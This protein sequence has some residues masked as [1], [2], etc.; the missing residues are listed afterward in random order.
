MLAYKLGCCCW[1]SQLSSS[2]LLFSIVS[3]PTSGI[4]V[5]FVFND[6]GEKIKA[7]HTGSTSTAVVHGHELA[8]TR[9]YPAVLSTTNSPIL[10][11]TNYGEW[12]I[13]MDLGLQARLLW[14][15]IQGVEDL[16]DEIGHRNNRSAMEVI[17]LLGSE[18]F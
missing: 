15:T 18:R 4:V 10:S 1:S 8:V 17:P 6:Y 11:R 3:I 9:S 12:A 7:S 2:L 16:T 5:R 13:L 14:M